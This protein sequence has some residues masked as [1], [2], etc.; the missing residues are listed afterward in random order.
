MQLDRL[1]PGDGLVT[2]NL[3]ATPTVLKAFRQEGY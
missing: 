2:L 3:Y 1:S